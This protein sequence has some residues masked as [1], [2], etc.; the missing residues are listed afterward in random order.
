MTIALPK[1]PLPAL[2]SYELSRYR[3]DL[4]HAIKGISPGAPVEADLR[5]KLG[6]VIA[7]QEDRTRLAAR[8]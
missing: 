4:E 3:R 8:A 6:A 7:E 1:H 5:R 2:T